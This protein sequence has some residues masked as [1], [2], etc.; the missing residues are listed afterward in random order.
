MSDDCARSSSEARVGA[1]DLNIKLGN[2]SSTCSFKGDLGRASK[3]SG[4]WSEQSREGSRAT[5]EGICA[6]SG[7]R[8]KI[9]EEDREA[10]K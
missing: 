2:S 10:Q 3:I 7:K 8:S 9:K 1:R 5:I 4:G 6:T